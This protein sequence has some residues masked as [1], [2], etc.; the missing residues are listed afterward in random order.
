MHV[1]Q[2]ADT[3]DALASDLRLDTDN[4]AYTTCRGP[5]SDGDGASKLYSTERG[6]VG[7]LPGPNALPMPNRLL[8]SDGH[9]REPRLESEVV[10]AMPKHH[11][12]CVAKTCHCSL[13]FPFNRLDASYPVGVP[14]IWSQLWA[15]HSRTAS[16]PFQAD[17]KRYRGHAYI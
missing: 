9:R 3:N 7:P 5:W 8:R 14:T 15:E 10:R 11:L 12:V 13:V 16:L 4:S 1:V 17:A 2:G 6:F